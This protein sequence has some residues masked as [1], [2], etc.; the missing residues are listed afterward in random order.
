MDI[1]VDMTVMN[2][3][4]RLPLA[5][6]FRIQC[7]VNRISLLWIPFAFWKVVTVQ[8]T[9]NERISSAF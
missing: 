6:Y 4:L 2:K 9:T 8:F 3:L 5:R 1:V 7:H